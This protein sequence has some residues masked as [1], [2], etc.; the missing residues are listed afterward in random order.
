[1]YYD[2]T[3]CISPEMR[4][5]AN[6]NDRFSLIGHLGTHFDV[7]DK[8]FPLEYLHRRAI[9]FDVSSIR[10]RDIGAEDIDMSLIQED[11]FVGFFT[12]CAAE[13]GY[14]QKEYFH[15]PVA[16]S[17]ALI[18]QL[19]ACRISIIGIDCP[20]IRMGKEHT[21]MDQHCAD[22]GVFIVE[23]MSGMEKLL[24]GDRFKHCEINTYPVSYS[25]MTG[26]P[27]RVVAEI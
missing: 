13:F 3:L 24:Q 15:S 2:L 17:E 18:E 27:C 19:I 26:L 21:P 14:G 10:N 12:G 20:G 4:K 23:N 22:H 8:E 11:M 1:M 9:V 16:L 25:G 7:M 5:D 6:G